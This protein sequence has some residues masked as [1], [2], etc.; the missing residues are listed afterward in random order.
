MK[1]VWPVITALVLVFGLSVAGCGSSSDDPP[2]TTQPG[3]LDDF[4]EI[5][6]DIPAGTSAANTATGEGSS[7]LH[8]FE[9]DD[10]AKI[11]NA[12]PG[13]LLEVVYKTSV[14]WACG[15]IGWVS[16]TEAGPVI[17]G[18]A[19]SSKTRVAYV[20]VEDLVL[21]ADH[22]TIH[23]FNG[24]T[25]EGVTLF[26][27]PA[28]YVVE[29]DPKAVDGGTKIFVPFGNKPL[30]KGDMSKADITKI[31]AAPDTSKLVFYFGS[32]EG[33]SAGIL[34]VASKNDYRG[35]PAYGL[36]V[37][38]T[39]PEW[40]TVD[41]EKKVSVP[42]STIKAAMTGANVTKLDINIG[43]SAVTGLEY[44]QIVP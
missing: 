15:E 28:D 2:P 6:L 26:E 41:T 19:S 29:A 42:I 3:G 8:K 7:K 13:S 11:K 17:H 21:G 9:G 24:A 1:K 43:D 31:L 5:V 39:D 4:D 27:A 37:T 30:G 23:I 38:V 14:S 25:V 12:N 32:E 22:F 44:I 34:K 36:A 20:P 18:D 16:I 35:S 40:S 33:T 10:F